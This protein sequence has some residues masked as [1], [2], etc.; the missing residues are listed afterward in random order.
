MT[1]SRADRTPAPPAFAAERVPVLAL[2]GAAGSSRQWLGL[3]RHLGDCSV[4]V[5]PDLPGYGTAFGQSPCDAA[6]SA[7]RIIN[8]MA[9]DDEP[10]HIVGHSIGAA[11]ALEIAMS[12]P[13]LVR[14]LTLIEPAVFHLLADGGPFEAAMF[15]ELRDLAERMARSVEAG[16]GADAMRAYADYW[17]AGN[18]DRSGPALRDS[19]ARQA[20]CVSASFAASL[21]AK[22]T[23][24]SLAMLQMPARV[25]MAL[26][27][28]AAS[29]RVTEMVAEALPRVRLTMMPGAGH[30]SLLKDSHMVSPLIAEH[31][32]CCDFFRNRRA[33]ISSA[34]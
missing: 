5:A 20:A 29:L 24:A 14:S 3:A 30:L 9:I 21:R 1:N 23:P 11:V 2:H 10:M 17:G 33:P 18:W 8:L 4:V 31:L 26:D 32:K 34:A 28:P 16:D 19:L 15:G 27:S 25:L 7:E 22:W 12:R 6:E 13:D